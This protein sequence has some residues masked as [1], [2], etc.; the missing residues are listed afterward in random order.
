MIAFNLSQDPVTKIKFRAASMELSARFLRDGGMFEAASFVDQMIPAPL[1]RSP[2]DLA[3]VSISVNA[4]DSDTIVRSTRRSGLRYVALLL[5]ELGIHEDA[6]LHLER[7][8]DQIPRGDESAPG[9]RRPRPHRLVSTGPS[10]RSSTR[11]SSR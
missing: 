2:R 8:A 3:R 10:R 1:R 4:K 6:A 7:C 5:R 9:G 11:H